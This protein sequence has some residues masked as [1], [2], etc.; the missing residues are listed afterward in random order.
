MY[1]YTLNMHLTAHNYSHEQKNGK[2]HRSKSYT[3]PGGFLSHG[4]AARRKPRLVPAVPTTPWPFSTALWNGLVS[5]A[6]LTQC[7]LF[8]GPSRL[9]TYWSACPWGSPGPT[10]GPPNGWHARYDPAACQ[11]SVTSVND[12]NNNDIMEISVAAQ[13]THAW[14][15]SQRYTVTSKL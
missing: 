8:Y 5:V 10:Q 11:W 13:T 3:G 14:T 2:K 1:Y 15:A 6:W 7:P 12:N 4:T 9:V